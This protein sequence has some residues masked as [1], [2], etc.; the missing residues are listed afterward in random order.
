MYLCMKFYPT[1]PFQIIYTNQLTKRKNIKSINIYE[2]FID[3]EHNYL[4]LEFF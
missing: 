3:L 2:T 4:I 1:L